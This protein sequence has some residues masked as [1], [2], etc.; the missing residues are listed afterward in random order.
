M[1]AFLCV[2]VL[3]AQEPRPNEYQVKAAYLFNFGRFVKWPATPTA[4]KDDSF[5]VCV[6]GQ[7][8]FGPVLDSTLAG[9]DLDGKRVATRRISKPQDA[10]TCRILFISSEEANHLK[11]I[12]S[13]L[14]E[15]GVLT[16]SDMP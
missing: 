15:E 3:R 16:V 7:D 12:L 2:P 11:E 1:L 6:L 4:G 10:G 5:T 13:S 9:E 8:P 14:D